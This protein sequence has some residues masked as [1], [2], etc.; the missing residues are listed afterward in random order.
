MIAVALK[1][2]SLELLSCHLSA[3][4]HDRSAVGWSSLF[5]GS[6]SMHAL[7]KGLG[8]LKIA[9]NSSPSPSV[10]DQDQSLSMGRGTLQVRHLCDRRSF[11]ANQ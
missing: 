1:K 4:D 3:S 8:D 10:G 11:D 5:R 6:C 9:M 2:T 7:P